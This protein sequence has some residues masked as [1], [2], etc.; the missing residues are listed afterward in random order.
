[1]N[2]DGTNQIQGRVIAERIALRYPMEDAGHDTIEGFSYL[3]AC[4]AALA[5]AIIFSFGVL[6]KA[7]VPVVQLQRR[8]NPN[9][10]PIASLARLPQVGVTRAER[11][12]A[13]RQANGGDGPVFTCSD[14]LREVKGIGPAIASG[15]SDFLRFDKED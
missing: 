8:I 12:A 7:D 13:Y 15:L 3:L 2:S 9:D 11:I 1:M 5:L 6:S 4:T 10:A 14:D